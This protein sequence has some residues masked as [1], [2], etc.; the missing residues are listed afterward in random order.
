MPHALGPAI[1]CNMGRKRPAHRVGA[2]LNPPGKP[3]TTLGPHEASA[4]ASPG[5]RGG[6]E[7]RVRLSRRRQRGA[8][9]PAWP[10][11]PRSL[12]TAGWR[13]RD[14]TLQEETPLAPAQT[15]TS[16]I[17]LPQ[18]FLHWALDRRGRA[19]CCSLSGV[20]RAGGTDGRGG[21][22]RALTRR[23]TLRGRDQRLPRDPALAPR[24]PHPSPSR[25]AWT[26]SSSPSL[27]PY[28]ICGTR[29]LSGATPGSGDIGSSP[30]VQTKPALP[31]PGTAWVL[32]APVQ[33]V[34]GPRPHSREG[35]TSF[36]LERLEGI[37]HAWQRRGSSL[38]PLPFPGCFCPV[39]GPA[40]RA[41][42]WAELGTRQEGNRA[43]P[44]AG[45][46]EMSWT[47]T[48]PNQIWTFDARPRRHRELDAP[49]LP[50]S[51]TKSRLGMGRV[52]L[53]AGC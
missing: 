17:L 8:G 11:G 44:A 27:R 19:A 43:E 16:L 52:E 14:R 36:W 15:I 5:F 35:V 1:M 29:L 40:G 45:E 20:L 53:G 6:S 2:R 30:V 34:E 50:T 47:L 32:P 46:G 13:E 42:A 39:K 37:R 51:G 28:Q 12:R 25:R 31:G 21:V 23:P 33:W 9:L 4:S 22:V 38:P 48:A 41:A 49:A 10:G 7:Q 26:R 3:R 18:N 24:G